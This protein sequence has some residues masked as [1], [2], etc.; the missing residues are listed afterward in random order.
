MEKK[1]KVIIGAAAVCALLLIAGIAIFGKKQANIWYID[2]NLENS[3]TRIL[4]NLRETEVP[5]KFVQ[6]KVWDEA[7]IPAEAGIL[8]TTNP[9]KTEEIVSVYPRLSWELEHEGAIVVALDPWMVFRKHTNPPLTVSRVFSETGGSGGANATGGANTAGMLLIPGREISAVRAWTSR[10]IMEE[11][12]KFPSEYAIWQEWERELFA[13]NRF[14]PGAT[15][16]DWHYAFFRL[17][18]NDIVWVYAPL[19]QIRR[20][21]DPNKSILEATP[22]P[23]TGSESSLQATILW[24]L[25]TG[26][27]KNKKNL[28][29]TIDWLKNPQTQT[30]IADALEWIPADPYG[31]PYDPVSFTT[32]RVWLTAQWVYTVNK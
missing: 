24:A 4:R 20:Y 15:G 17:M 2:Q 22:F 25:P 28:A 6:I 1:Q 13:A 9:R 14:L 19:S 8:I 31:T 16:H 10:F 11:P 23:E 18:G 5:N 27:E 30:I 21:R 3:W 7:E 29:K 26:T 12:G 32:Q